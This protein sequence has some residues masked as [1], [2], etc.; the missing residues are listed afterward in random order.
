MRK[1]QR[2][3]CSNARLP[4]SND[5]SPLALALTLPSRF[6]HG[7]HPAPPLMIHT[8]PEATPGWDAILA[9]TTA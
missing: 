8:E 7:F 2:P 6:S 4:R 1:R 9:T 3:E 5:A